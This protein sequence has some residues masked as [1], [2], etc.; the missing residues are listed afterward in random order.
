MNNPTIKKGQEITLVNNA[1]LK[2]SSGD[3]FIAACD[4]FFSHPANP[5][6]YIYIEGYPNMHLC[7]SRF[8]EGEV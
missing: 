4:S 6:E 1:H 3:K 8:A 5:T 7:V 2:L